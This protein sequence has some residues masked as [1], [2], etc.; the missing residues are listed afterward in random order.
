MPNEH[1]DFSTG[2]PPRQVLV[3]RPRQPEAE[4]VTPAAESEELLRYRALLDAALDVT[5]Q[6]DVQAVFDHALAGLRRVVRFTGASI[7]L[8]DDDGIRIAAAVPDPTP[9]ALS[10]RIPLGQGVSGAIALS[11]E[12]RYLPDITIASTVTARRRIKNSSTGVRSWYGV[13]LVADGRPIGVLQI[14]STEVDA[15]DEAD[16]LA[17]LAFAPVVA[18]GLTA[19]SRSSAV[20]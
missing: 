1:L 20:S 18:L 3:P 7:L 14:D 2:L 11:G 15:F 9:E 13:P 5:A 12:P 16:Q 8:V 4:T 17:V 19:V 10:A 6:S